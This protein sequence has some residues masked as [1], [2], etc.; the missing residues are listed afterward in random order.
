V[1]VKVRPLSTQLNWATID[2]NS[3]RI[4][5]FASVSDAGVEIGLDCN[6]VLW[7]LFNECTLGSNGSKQAPFL[8]LLHVPK[9]LRITLLLSSKIHVLLWLVELEQELD[10][11]P[12]SDCWLFIPLQQITCTHTRNNYLLMRVFGEPQG[13]DFV[14]EFGRMEW[15]AGDESWLMC[16][17]GRVE[18]LT[19]AWYLQFGVW[20]G[21]TAHRGIRA[22]T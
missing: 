16:G 11:S 19:C 14:V 3:A 1:R 22:H 4:A 15:I 9:F 2:S 8:L 7:H 6:P 5:D 13:Y 20:T 12:S 10:V 17:G 18:I 21:Y